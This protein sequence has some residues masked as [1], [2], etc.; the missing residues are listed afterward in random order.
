MGWYGDLWQWGYTT[1]YGAFAL[2]VAGHL[3]VLGAA[4]RALQ[5]RGVR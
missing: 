4:T 3:A 5:R 1:G 2:V